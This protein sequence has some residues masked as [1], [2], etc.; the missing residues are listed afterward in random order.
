MIPFPNRYRVVLY[1]SR[2]TVFTVVCIICAHM[3]CR[4][5]SQDGVAD[6]V[7]DI[8]STTSSKLSSPGC[9]SVH[10]GVVFLLH[11]QGFHP[12]TS[13]VVCARF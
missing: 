5:R 13:S 9:I 6:T 10:V 12:T 4:E 7:F 3:M 8:P 11:S 2:I 1:Y